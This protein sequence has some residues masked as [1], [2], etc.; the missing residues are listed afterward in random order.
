MPARA[1]SNRPL[2]SVP[3]ISLEEAQDQS[4]DPFSHSLKV[5]L[6]A[7]WETHL[8]IPQEVGPHTLAQLRNLEL[9]CDLTSAPLS[10]SPGADFSPS[11][12]QSRSSLAH[13]KTQWEICVPRGRPEELSLSCGPSKLWS[14]VSSAHPETY[15]MMQEEPHSPMHLVTSL[16][17]T[18]PTTDPE[19]DP[20]PSASPTD[21]GLGCRFIHPETKQD[22]YL[23]EPLL[24]SLP[25][26][27]PSSSYMT[28]LQPYLTS[29]VRSQG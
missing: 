20:C 8:C 27:D 4:S 22:L 10:Y 7:Y 13:Q 23:L 24:T 11:Q 18:D 2:T 19:A 29:F 14:K 16:L 12:P 28:W 1:W 5:I 21:Q 15:A 26:A 17:S 25:T 6:P 3:I 9:S